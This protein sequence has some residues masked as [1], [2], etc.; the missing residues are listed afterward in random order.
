[1]RSVRLWRVSSSGTPRFC[2]SK[3]RPNSLL[4]GW[5]IS[6]DTRLKPKARLCPARRVRAIISRASGSCAA[7]AF[8]RFLRRISSHTNGS[9]PMSTPTS[10]RSTGWM[11][12]A[13]PTTTPP[14]ASPP[15][16]I[17]SLVVVRLVSACSN[18]RPMLPNRW[19]NDSTMPGPL[20]SGWERM[21][22]CWARA[23]WRP[24]RHWRR[25]ARPGGLRSSAAAFR[26]TTSAAPPTIAA[27][28]TNAKTAI[29]S[30]LTA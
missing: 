25:S 6:A 27:T 29:S 16:I 10:G 3:T 30:G 5:G 17:A 1:M 7:K 13:V 26:A 12:A 4:I 19:R 14:S 2:S 20:S 23:F 11:R 22:L 18:K 9:D 28:P 21:L 15:E 8:R 24:R